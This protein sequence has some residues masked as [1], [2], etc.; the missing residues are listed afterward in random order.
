[1]LMQNEELT[2]KIEELN[3]KID[4]M[5]D[6]VRELKNYFKWILIITVAMIV[7]PL[8]GLMFVVPSFL[9]TYSTISTF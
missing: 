7:L 9:S 4:E 5:A 8:V 3:A 1:M 2:K 6:S